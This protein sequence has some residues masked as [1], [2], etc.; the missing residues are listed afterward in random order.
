MRLLL[1]LL[2]LT[3]V[4]ALSTRHVDGHNILLIPAMAHGHVRYFAQ[5]GRP[6]I[7]N[8]HRVHAIINGACQMAMEELDAVNIRPLTY[9]TSGKC[10]L[11]FY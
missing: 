8:G 6:L 1:L 3:A 10:H 9:F 4:L 5:V 2:L 11:H 7:D